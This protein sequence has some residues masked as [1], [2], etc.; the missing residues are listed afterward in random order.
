MA[1]AF[2]K[3]NTFVRELRRRRVFRVAAVYGIMAFVIIQVVEITFPA[4]QIPDWA[5]SLVVVMLLLG[6]PIA[7]GLAWAFDVTPE[8]VRRTPP[9][10]SKLSSPQAPT[11]NKALF[12]SRP[13]YLGFLALLVLIVIILVVTR[14]RPSEDQTDLAQSRLRHH[15]VKAQAVAVARS[16]VS[17]ILVNLEDP[18]SRPAE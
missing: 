17:K 8:G 4:L 18:V 2:A 1:D 7:V 5:Q 16:G 6:F 10:A 15:F 13:F 14:E 12:T 11:T 3:I 9:A